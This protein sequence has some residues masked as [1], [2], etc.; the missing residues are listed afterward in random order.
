VHNTTVKTSTGEESHSVR[1][2]VKATLEGR[3]TIDIY[4]IL[5]EETDDVIVE[6]SY[7][8]NRPGKA[9]TSEARRTSHSGAYHLL[10]LDLGKSEVARRACE[11]AGLTRFDE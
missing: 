7:T 1:L 2:L 6:Q 9:P 3:L 11:R 5:D 4:S 8:T 10:R